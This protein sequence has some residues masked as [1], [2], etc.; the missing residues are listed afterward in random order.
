MKHRI[1]MF[2]LIPLGA[3]L[4]QLLPTWPVF[5]GI[6]PPILAALALHYALR[7]NNK[8]MW[9]AIFACAI[10]QDGLDLGPFGPA[11]LAFPIIGILAQRI[12]N[13]IFADGLVSQ[14]FF[15]AAIGFFTTFVALLIYTATGLRP[16]H[17][18]TATLRLFGA[19]C[20]GA[21]TLPLVSLTV[22][23]LEN[24]LPKRR[25]YGWQ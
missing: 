12:R 7:R 15:G 21:I 11:L 24:V 3:L 22:N 23:K 10:M 17:A 2:L 9:I 14:L 4:Q 19:L 16:F 18:G 13:E 20:L 5:G 25:G 6:K 8:D 1:L